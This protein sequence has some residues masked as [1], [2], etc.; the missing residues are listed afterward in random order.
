[1]VVYLTVCN[2][3]R[4]YFIE[5]LEG[6]KMNRIARTSVSILSVASLLAG[7]SS[8]TTTATATPE[9]TGETSSETS[10]TLRVGMECNYAP[11]NWTTTTAGETTQPISSVDYCDGYD[12]V[13]ATTI[14]EELGMNV[15]IVKT[16]WDNLIPALNNGEIDA[17][18]AGMTATDERRQ[19][20]DFTEPYYISQ[21]VIIVPADSDLV[22]ITSI[23][24]L[25]GYTVMGQ[26][27]TLYDDIIDQIDGVVHATPKE[28]YPSMVYSL[29]QG[30]VDAITAELPVAQGV[31]SANPDL[32]IVEFDE[33]N[34]FVSD[35][36]VSIAIAKG[37]EEL[38][39][40]IQGVLDSISEDQRQQMMLDAVNRQP[41]VGD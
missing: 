19:S 37:N 21:N 36:S 31:V 38:L 18:I 10:D 23:Q 22:G 40:S 17:I 33:A 32:T 7:C 8:P 11:F 12:V 13:V 14:A 41:S 5:N 6:I 1:M 35:A 28:D 25:S 15:E 16:D 30:E 34:G 26:L 2:G 39:A 29:Q 4:F 24:D 27:N 9:T 20:V 3:I